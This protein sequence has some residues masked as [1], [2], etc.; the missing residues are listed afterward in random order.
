MAEE[1]TCNGA[2]CKGGRVGGPVRGDSSRG[3]DIVLMAG[4]S[5]KAEAMVNEVKAKLGCCGL[6]VA[7]EHTAVDVQC[8][9]TAK[10]GTELAWEPVW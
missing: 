4:T 5:K 10:G 8:C 6:P 3:D 2:L 1:L 7:E 9:C